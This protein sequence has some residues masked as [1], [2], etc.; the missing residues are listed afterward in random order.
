MGRTNRVRLES[1]CLNL[2]VET[3]GRREGGNMTQ[4]TE[5]VPCR[6]VIQMV[7][8]TKLF[9]GIVSMASSCSFLVSST[10]V[11]IDENYS[12]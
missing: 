7:W 6:R 4:G 3:W 11:C 12:L 9:T 2:G 10:K 8:F 1:K 5:F